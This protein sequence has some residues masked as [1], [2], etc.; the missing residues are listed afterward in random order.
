[1]KRGISILFPALMI[2]AGC[3][4]AKKAMKNTES[5]MTVSMPGIVAVGDDGRRIHPYPDTSYTVFI[6]WKGEEPKWES[7]VKGQRSFS[8]AATR[9]D[10]SVQVGKDKATGEP[11]TVQAAEGNQLWQLQLV[12][13]AQFSEAANPSRKDEIII[14]GRYQDKDFSKKIHNLRE[15]QAKQHE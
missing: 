6:E 13:T 2:I 5:F 8:I 11:V 4:P 10:G 12:P 7:A 15:L 1:M 9:M 14:R 3:N